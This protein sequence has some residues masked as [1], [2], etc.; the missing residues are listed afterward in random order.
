MDKEAL[1]EWQNRYYNK[2]IVDLSKHFNEE[3]IQTLKKLGFEIQNKKYT[4]YEFEVIKG[5]VYLYYKD[6]TF[7]EEDLELTK[8]LEE[9]GVSEK[10]YNRLFGKLEKISRIYHI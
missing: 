5:E 2:G 6:E 7:S 8:S 10:A 9:K 3:N 1:L 4:E